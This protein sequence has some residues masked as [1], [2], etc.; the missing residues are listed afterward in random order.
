MTNVPC[1]IVRHPFE[2]VHVLGGAVGVSG[3]VPVY[4]SGVVDHRKP[5]LGRVRRWPGNEKDR[6]ET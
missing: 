3:I 4:V 6:M 5:F 1:Y 2:Q